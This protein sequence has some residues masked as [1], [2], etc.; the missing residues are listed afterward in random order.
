MRPDGTRRYR[1]AYLE[2]PKKNGKSMM[3]SALALYHL[4]ADGEQGAE[5]YINAYDKEQA[6]F[7]YTE[8]ERTVKASPELRKI[9]DLVAS[10]KRI[11]HR[12]SNSYLV[13]NSAEVGNK[14]G[15]SPSLCIF[16]ELH[17][18]R[19]DAMWKMF[20][21]ASISR[22]QPLHI[23]ITTAGED[24]ESICYKQHELSEKV[25]A[26]IVPDI[27]H[28]GVIYAADV[29][30]D[31]EDP[32]TW[33]K[34]NPSF[35]EDFRASLLKA[36]ATPSLLS[37]FLR[38]RLNLW[39]QENARFLSREAWTA[40]Q[41]VHFTLDTMPAGS[42]CFLGGDLSTTTD[43]TALVSIFGD[44]ETGIDV[45]AKFWLPEDNID[46]LS[47]K[48]RVD[49]RLWAE[50]GFLE[51]TSGPV[52][53]YSYIR[54]HINALAKRFNVLKLLM[55]PHNATQLI[56]ELMDDGINVETIR[57]GYIS[58]S[59]PTKEL[60]RLVIAKKLRHDGNPVLRWMADN[61]VAERD[62]A[63]NLKLSK[64][65]SRLKI[66]GMAALVN[67]IAGTITNSDGCGSVYE[68]RGVIVV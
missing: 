16:D 39:L 43:L 1:S 14:D 61:A 42:S 35:E 50:Q 30:D 52:I 63:G 23:S 4:I 57:Q 6:G 5:V 44:D 19:T 66:D 68:T 58:L 21:E 47:R 9:L 55:D 31:I 3:V 56:I 10:K 62:A 37:N 8:A 22:E 46:E 24:L 11:T 48:N 28:L 20:T 45:F 41:G 12:A 34:A 27:S 67:A 51:L 18:Q 38:L 32:D 7:I 33:R 53:D 40:C 25:N 60:E 36:K 17:R 29:D 64:A 59:P 2:V 15:F 54:A 49:Y 65:K 26:G 13:A